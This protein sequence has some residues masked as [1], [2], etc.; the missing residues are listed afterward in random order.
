MKYILIVGTKDAGKSTTIDELC[1]RLQPTSM[2]CLNSLKREFTR[3][4]LDEIV[5]NGTFLLQVNG[6]IIL[7]VAGAPTE[8]QITITV[9]I[10]ICVKLGI[11]IDFAIVAMRS[12]ETR[13]GHSTRRELQNFGNCVLDERIRRIDGD[14][15]KETSEWQNRIERILSSIRETVGTENKISAVV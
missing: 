5:H 4:S 10:E 9:I 14:N 11:K 12:F 6:E 8:Q 7:V 15:F 3:I 13:F 2:R 1:K